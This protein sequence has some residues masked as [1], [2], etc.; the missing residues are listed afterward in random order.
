MQLRIQSGENALLQNVNIYVAVIK[1]ISIEQE[2]QM[3]VT[4]HNELFVV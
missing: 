4:K 1:F 2:L 3:G